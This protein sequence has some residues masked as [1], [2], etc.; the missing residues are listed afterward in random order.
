MRLAIERNV[1]YHLFAKGS[2][3][4]TEWPR[5]ISDPSTAASI[6]LRALHKSPTEGELK[7][8]SG[9]EETRL[10]ITDVDWKAHSPAQF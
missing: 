4:L 5:A 2:R 1:T 6:L 10:P 9:Q 3:R 7:R 8:I